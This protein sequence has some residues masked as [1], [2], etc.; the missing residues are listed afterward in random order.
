MSI[1]SLCLVLL[2]AQLIFSMSQDSLIKMSENSECIKAV[3][4]SFIKKE[5]CGKLLESQKSLVN[6]FLI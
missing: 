2:M 3:V 5:S 6:D 4:D 1:K